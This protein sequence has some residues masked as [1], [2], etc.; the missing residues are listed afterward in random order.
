MERHGYRSVVAER[1]REEHETRVEARLR[2]STARD[3]IPAKPQSL[4]EIRR[5]ARESW[6]QMRRA[7]PN[8]RLVIPWSAP[9]MTISRCSIRRSRMP[10]VTFIRPPERE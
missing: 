2:R 8:Q 6:L 9:R 1:M 5:Q 10:L 3:A 7:T 4:E